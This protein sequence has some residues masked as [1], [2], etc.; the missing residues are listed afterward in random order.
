ME[1]SDFITLLNA[2]SPHSQVQHIW[3]DLSQIRKVQKDIQI[4][5]IDIRTFTYIA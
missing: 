1:A 3:T 5:S 4:S 2:V